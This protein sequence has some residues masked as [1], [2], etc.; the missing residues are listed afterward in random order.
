MSISWGADGFDV[1]GV[2]CSAWCCQTLGVGDNVSSSIAIA[3]MVLHAESEHTNSDG[4]N[5]LNTY[6]HLFRVCIIR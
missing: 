3:H 6:K 2:I 1:F 4:M 5:A